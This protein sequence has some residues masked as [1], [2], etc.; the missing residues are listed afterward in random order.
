MVYNLRGAGKKQEK[1]AKE[2]EYRILRAL[3]N[4]EYGIIDEKDEDNPR[5]RRARW[6][7]RLKFERGLRADDRRRFERLDKRTKKALIAPRYGLGFNELAR[8]TNLSKRT[9]LKAIPRLNTRH[10]K[11]LIEK[12]Y[13][14]RKEIGA[15]LRS[16]NR[17]DVYSKSLYDR[18]EKS[19]TRLI[20]YIRKGGDLSIA[21][22][23]WELTKLIRTRAIKKRACSKLK[24]ARALMAKPKLVYRLARPVA[25]VVDK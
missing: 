1:Q 6:L 2:S 24:R 12:S 23:R 15:L 22:A 8:I 9:V 14:N 18:Y 10:G 16:I 11:I 19:R 25:H 13:D 7:D 4:F 21:E 17:S 5:K 20:N 3:G